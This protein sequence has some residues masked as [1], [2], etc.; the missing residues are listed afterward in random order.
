M[1]LRASWGQV[2]NNNI[3]NNLYRASVTLSGAG[4]NFGTGKGSAVNV[5][6]AY[7]NSLGNDELTWETS[8]Q[9]NIGI[10]ARFLNSRLGLNF[11]W[12]YKVT[13]DWLVQ[14]PV[15]ATAGVSSSG[16]PY[17]N[18]GDVTNK[19]VEVGLTWNDQIGEDFMYNVG[20]NLSYNK[21]EV[22]SIPTEGG[23]L[24]GSTNIMFNNQTE[25]YR[26]SN[27]EPMGYFWGYKTAG[28]FQN[29][30]EIDEWIA[31]GNG[32]LN[33]VAPGEAKF[34]DVD[35]NGV[36]DDA[37]K[38][39]LGNGIPKFNFGFNLGFTYKNFDFSTTWTGAAG[40]KV[41]NGG[42]RNWGNSSQANYTTYFLNRWTGEGTSNTVPRL[43][44]NDSSW[45][46]FSD[47]YLQDGDYLR[48]SNITLGYDFAKLI[49]CK[50]ISQARLYVQAQ[51]L[52]TFTNYNG[53][54]PEVGFGQDTWMSGI[55][56]GSYP[57][58]RTFLVGVNLKF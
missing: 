57:H 53:M 6:G 55:D 27:G 14:A 20:A 40:F 39:N 29:Q 24:H 28:I 21:N 17:I 46:N 38:V 7:P 16:W 34:V 32:V 48:I 49:S 47:L 43:T 19:G 10:D 51:N 2:G 52:F 22:G 33:S 8:E 15:I 3:G 35:H 4:Y 25:F 45:T 37:D 36:I 30:Q 44:N 1:K 50:Y 5:V 26:C 31:A 58:A 42:Y 18:G 12:Y 56:T 13:R 54:D 41:A 23:I 9:T 11:D